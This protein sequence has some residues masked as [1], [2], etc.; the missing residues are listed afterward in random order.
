MENIEK[1]VSDKGPNLTSLLMGSH[2]YKK[3][4]SHHSSKTENPT[5]NSIL[6]NGVKI[7]RNGK[8]RNLEN[9]IDIERRMGQDIEMS[10]S[11]IANEN[12]DY[13]DEEMTKTLDWD[14]YRDEK[15]RNLVSKTDFISREMEK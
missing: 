7:V 9:K 10:Q 4:I 6:G 3:G 2:C 15:L 8:L 12:A 1:K 14:S 13:S 11:D 5:G